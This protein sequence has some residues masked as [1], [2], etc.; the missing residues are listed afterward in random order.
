[1]TPDELLTKS[2]GV[3]VKTTLVDFPGHV[4]ST[5][6]LKGCNL[7]C[8][9]CYNVDLV[10]GGQT[11]GNTNDNFK[12]QGQTPGFS[13]DKNQSGG[14]EVPSTDPAP[15]QYTS[16][17][18]VLEHLYKRRNVIKGLVISGGEPLLNPVTPLLIARAKSM[19]LKIKLD[20]NGTL[21]LMLESLMNNPDTRPDFIAMDLKTSP[22][23]Y[24]TDIPVTS[25]FQNADIPDLL[26]A[27][28]DII[29]TL[30]P[31]NYEIRTVLVPPLVTRTDIENIAALLPHDAS[32]QFAP[33][34]NE[35]CLDPSYN[36][37]VPYLDK[38]LKA[39]VE[40]AQPLIPGAALR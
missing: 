20:T 19:G 2:Q 10:A 11:S 12:S 23:R 5:Y 22:S 18:E 27:S 28:V 29:K 24:K 32:W 40:F 1:M 35:N 6:F 8:P 21:P 37:V 26:K 9:Y 15:I 33:F 25:N 39:L 7:R 34:R 14:Q 31:A 4:A 17:V 16:P 36:A 13:S 3:L 30:G 38:D